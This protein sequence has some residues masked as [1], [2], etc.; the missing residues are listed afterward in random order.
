M[1]RNDA[2]K[3]V[4]LL[5]PLL[6]NVNLIPYNEIEG[7]PFKKPEAAKIWQFYQWLQDGGLNVSIR[8]ERGSDINAACGQLRSDYRR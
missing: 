2:N 7:L 4:K 1:S 6:A 8:E 3:M 5:K